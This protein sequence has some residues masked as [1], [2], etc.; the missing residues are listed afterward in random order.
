MK[1]K[2]LVCLLIVAML[3]L[4]FAGCGS[5]EAK[6]EALGSNLDETASLSML[7]VY[8]ED[9]DIELFLMRNKTPYNLGLVAPA[10]RAYQYTLKFN[11]K[12][13]GSLCIEIPN[14]LLSSR[15]MPTPVIHDNDR[16]YATESESYFG[17][18]VVPLKFVGYSPLFIKPMPQPPIYEE[19]IIVGETNGV[20]NEKT[21][22]KNL[23]FALMD[24][25][26]EVKE[27]SEEEIR[28]LDYKQTVRISWDGEK[29]KIYKTSASYPYYEYAGNRIELS[30]TGKETVNG[31]EYN[32]YDPTKLEKGFY[33]LY[34]GEE[35]RSV[36]VI[37]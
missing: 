17:I 26:K 27:L 30:S 19:Y 9:K 21:P 8:E 35:A 14:G 32:V 29:G 33:V 3:T 7:K 10:N 15:N 1:K 20:L 37:Q 13:P 18:Y 12:E 6:P 31:S 11:N 28:Q 24:G 2:I 5:K 34:S 36:F 4:V 22:Y 25:D 16:I 23:R